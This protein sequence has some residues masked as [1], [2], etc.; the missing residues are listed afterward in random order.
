MLVWGGDDGVVDGVP[1]TKLEVYR[2]ISSMIGV[3][4][5]CS[6]GS[7]GMVMMGTKDGIG[8][9]VWAWGGS[10]E[11]GMASVIMGSGQMQ[12]VSQCGVS[13][14]EMQLQGHAKYLT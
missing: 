12:M 8:G 7:S 5:I 14:E 1:T 9:I 11:M 6:M 2:L 4:F 3:D 13:L 10:E